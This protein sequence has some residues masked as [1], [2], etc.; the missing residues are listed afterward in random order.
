MTGKATTK[1]KSVKTPSK[2]ERYFEA[3]GRRKTAVARVRL[4]TKKEG[5]VI[6]EKAL[7][8]YF[9][10][11][12]WQQ[13]VLA[14]LDKMKIMDKLGA[15]V[16]V[17]GGGLSAQA[18]AIRHGISRALIDFNT[19]FKKRLRRAGYLTRDSRMVERKKYGKHKARRG[20]Q[21]RKR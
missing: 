12:R 8:E 18:E 5:I 1:E 16:K 21:W 7:K 15:V 17:K 9:P 13:E 19:D 20:H 14:P 3:V 6:N 4:F 11:N 2:K 10:I